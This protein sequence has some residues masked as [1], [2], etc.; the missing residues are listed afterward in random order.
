MSSKLLL[1][2]LWHACDVGLGRSYGHTGDDTTDCIRFQF[3]VLRGVYPAVDFDSHHK[4]LHLDGQPAG[5]LANMQKLLDLG[6]GT[7][8]ADASEKG[9]YV[10]QGW[11]G[12]SGHAIIL[13]RRGNGSLWIMD[14]TTA[15]TDGLRPIEWSDVTRRWPS[16]LLVKLREPT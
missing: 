15:T 2:F 7:E 6:V 14:F 9:V 12:A 8:A 10:Q 16:R 1:H 5:S 4:M 13:I 11:K 3:A